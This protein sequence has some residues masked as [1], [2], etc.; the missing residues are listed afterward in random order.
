MMLAV[1]SLSHKGTERSPETSKNKCIHKMTIEG[2]ICLYWATAKPSALDCCLFVAYFFIPITIPLVVSP[3]KDLSLESSQSVPWR[4][5]SSTRSLT[6]STAEQQRER[7]RGRVGDGRG[8]QR[9]GEQRTQ[10]SICSGLDGSFFS[11]ERAALNPIRAS[12]QLCPGVPCGDTKLANGWRASQGVGPGPACVES[13]L[14]EAGGWRC[15]FRTVSQN[16]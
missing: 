12:C 1:L 4:M 7:M 9:K 2:F 13:S 15:S 5:G 14:V 6:R 3:E 10:N 16:Y 11:L 8:G